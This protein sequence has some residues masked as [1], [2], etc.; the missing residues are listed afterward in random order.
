L[1]RAARERIEAHFDLARQVARF[2]EALAH[3]H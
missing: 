2:E 1:A 3:G